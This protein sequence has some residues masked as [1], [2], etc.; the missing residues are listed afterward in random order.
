MSS[1][2]NL[3]RYTALI[4]LL[5]AALDLCVVDLLMP[6]SC[7]Q[8]IAQSAPGSRADHDCLSLMARAFPGA[9]QAGR[10][11]LFA[12]SAARL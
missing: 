4:L 8:S 9:G 11:G 6:D 12:C 3:F 7:D 1:W 5:G 10:L 2:R